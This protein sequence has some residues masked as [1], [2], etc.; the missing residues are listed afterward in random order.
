MYPKIINVESKEPFVLKIKFDNEEIKEYDLEK[1]KELFNTIKKNGLF[2]NYTIDPGGYGVSF[3]DEIDI[4]EY[5]LYTNGI[6]VD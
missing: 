1:N 5:E 4:S 6:L 2:K 3:S